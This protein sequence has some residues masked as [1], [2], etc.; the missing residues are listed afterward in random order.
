MNNR[1]VNS[2]LK[3]KYLYADIDTYRKAPED[4]L[5]PQLPVSYIKLETLPSPAADWSPILKALRDGDGF[6]TT[7]EILFRKYAVEGSGDQ[8]TITADLE[9]TFPL[10]FLEIVWGDGKSIDRQIIR[11]TDL[12]PFGSK[13]FSFPFQAAGRSWVRMAAWDSAT[14]GAF[15]QPQWLW[16]KP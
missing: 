14:N 12:P 2:G 16:T 6:V 15:V 10:E 13:R 8:R 5:F 7:G 11:A 3:P 9:W 1:I 4:D